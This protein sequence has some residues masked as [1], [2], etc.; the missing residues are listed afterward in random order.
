MCASISWLLP[1]ADMPATMRE[2]R[3][4]IVIREVGNQLLLAQR[5]T[6]SRILPVRQLESDI[7][8]LA[9]SSD[10]SFLPEQL[11]AIASE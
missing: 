4:K 7:Y 2:E 5:D 3:S 8:V 6:I 11:V 10:L 9:F 1:Q